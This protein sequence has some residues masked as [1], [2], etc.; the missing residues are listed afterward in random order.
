MTVTM[1][2]DI[3]TPFRDKQLSQND[4]DWDAFTAHHSGT[5]P[6]IGDRRHPMCGG[7]GLHKFMVPILNSTFFLV[8]LNSR[9]TFRNVLAVEIS[10]VWKCNSQTTGHTASLKAWHILNTLHW[11]IKSRTDTNM[12]QSFSNQKYLFNGRISVLNSL[13]RPRI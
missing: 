6:G 1:T 8:L 9:L 12:H 3:W 2:T 5:V 13:H 7:T 10:N 4:P 11:H